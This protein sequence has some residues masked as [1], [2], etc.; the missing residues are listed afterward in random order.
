MKDK[1]KLNPFVTD[2]TMGDLPDHKFRLRW[3]FVNAGDELIGFKSSW[4]PN[5]Y[6]SFKESFVQ[7]AEK[8]E[9]AFLVI[10]GE[11]ID[12]AEPEKYEIREFLR[13]PFADLMGTDPETVEIEVDKK[14]NPTGEKRVLS[15]AA[16][17]LEYVGMVSSA[18]KS[19]SVVGALMIRDNEGN[20]A[21]VFVNGFI[22]LEEPSRGEK[23][24]FKLKGFEEAQKE[25]EQEA[26]EAA[27]ASEKSLEKVAEEQ[28]RKEEEEEA[29]K[30]SE[31]VPVEL[32][33]E[34]EKAL[35][36]GGK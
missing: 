4:T 32:P 9:A 15:G 26:E 5:D 8:Q 23:I 14:G 24:E 36:K 35:K 31:S 27:K 11:W 29:K 10:E 22:L 17:G 30:A 25:L 6:P 34:P 12:Q 19:P 2:W 13:F 7:N 3:F 16:R 28:K 18:P 1:I 33:K 20:K 21:W